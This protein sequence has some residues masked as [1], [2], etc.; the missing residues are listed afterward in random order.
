MYICIYPIG[1]VS[2]GTS[3]EYMWW[4]TFMHHSFLSTISQRY[5]YGHLPSR[6]RIQI[7]AESTSSH[8]CGQAGSGQSEAKAKQN[9]S[10]KM[11]SWLSVS[12]ASPVGLSTKSNGF[13]QEWSVHPR[14]CSR[15]P[16]TCPGNSVSRHCNNLQQ[17]RLARKHR[18]SSPQ[19]HFPSSSSI[20]VICQTSFLGSQNK[21][22]RPQR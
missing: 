2:L 20:T 7:K 22:P 10:P 4:C 18:G 15:L 1:S 8:F 6:A 13:D 5:S 19:P 11:E 12:G 14:F 16:H 3:D 17:Q 21:S 9:V